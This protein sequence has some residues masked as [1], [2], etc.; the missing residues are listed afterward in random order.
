MKTISI[1]RICKKI[2]ETRFE[3]LHCCET[4]LV[5]AVDVY[6]CPSCGI[7]YSDEDAASNCCSP[8]EMDGWVCERCDSA[9]LEEEKARHC[10]CRAQ[11]KLL[12]NEGVDATHGERHD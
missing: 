3:A 2:Y 10:R 9:Y 1:C 5:K 12:L 4:K 11:T 7:L 8:E 6:Q